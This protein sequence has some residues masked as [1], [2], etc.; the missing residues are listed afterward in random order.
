[1]IAVVLV[2]NGSSH[3]VL[4]RKNPSKFIVETIG[5]AGHNP[6]DRLYKL[7]VGAGIRLISARESNLIDFQRSS[8]SSDR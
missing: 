5:V 6:L 1:M 2:V 8:S 3:C 4:W 7:V